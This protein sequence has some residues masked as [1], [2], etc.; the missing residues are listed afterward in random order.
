MKMPDQI[1]DQ[2]TA[3]HT[4]MVLFA[5]LLAATE[6]ISLKEIQSRLNLPEEALQEGFGLL[7]TIIE[8]S[9]PLCLQEIEDKL[10]LGTKAEFGEYVQIVYKEKKQRLTDAALE[11]LAIIAYKQPVIKAELDKIRGVDCESTLAKLSSEGFIKVI[12][13]LSRPGKPVLYQTT[14]KFLM[15]FNLKGLKDL[16]SLR[17]LGR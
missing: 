4:A 8:S 13:N 7:R 10:I 15:T 2:T 1:T 6:P 11:T 12:G 16:P 9:T 3:Q 5:V 17:E 14:E